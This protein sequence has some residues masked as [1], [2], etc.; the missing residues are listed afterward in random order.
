M[1]NATPIVEVLDSSD[2]SLVAEYKALDKK[3]GEVNKLIEMANNTIRQQQAAGQ[4]LVGKLDVIIRIL[5]GRKINP[6]T[7]SPPIEEILAPQNADLPAETPQN[8]GEVV[9]IKGDPRVAAIK[10]RLKS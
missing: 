3:L 4:I 6:N 9:D 5:N 10:S 2:A 7:F 1:S 8:E